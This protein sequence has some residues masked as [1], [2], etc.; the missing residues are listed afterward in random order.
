MT[1]NRPFPAHPETCDYQVFEAAL[2]NDPNVFFHG[3]SAANLQSI[4]TDGFRFPD[5][6]KAQSV[7]FASTSSVPLRYASEARD[8]A[9][10][11]GCVIAVRYVELE[12]RGIEYNGSVL[13]DRILKPQPTIIA[14]CIVPSS[15]LH[16]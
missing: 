3:T 7:S 9:C 15:Y 16:S 11:E 14:Y 1:M 6:P 2:E 5:H 10:P 12:R 13:H 8:A 4:L